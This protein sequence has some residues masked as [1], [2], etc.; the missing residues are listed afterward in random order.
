MAN[1]VKRASTEI[2]DEDRDLL[3]RRCKYSREADH[4]ARLDLKSIW[5]NDRDALSRGNLYCRK[6]W[7]YTSKRDAG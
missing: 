5:E 1:S 6:T 3:L 2:F 4:S 7:G